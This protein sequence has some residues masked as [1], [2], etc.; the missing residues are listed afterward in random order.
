MGGGVAAGVELGDIDI[1][2]EK[3]PASFATIPLW[4]RHT[5]STE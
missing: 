1:A 3:K 2:E 5:T 4:S